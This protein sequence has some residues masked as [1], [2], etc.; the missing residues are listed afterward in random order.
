MGGEYAERLDQVQTSHERCVRHDAA[1]LIVILPSSTILINDPSKYGYETSK[2]IGKGGITFEFYRETKL[3]DD[4]T[5][6]IGVGRYV[7]LI[8][9]L[10]LRGRFEGIGDHGFAAKR[11]DVLPGDPFAAAARGYDCKSHRELPDLLC[12]RFQRSAVDRDARSGHI[13]SMVARQKCNE[14][15]ILQRVTEPSKR[16]SC[17]GLA[18]PLVKGNSL[19]P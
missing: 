6:I 4:A 1:D 13:I 15:A 16:G 2:I 5:N 8:E 19:L 11:D 9:Q 12:D 10:R 17:F 7:Y 14:P 18:L 3:L